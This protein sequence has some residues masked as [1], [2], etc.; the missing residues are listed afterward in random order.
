MK[1]WKDKHFWKKLGIAFIAIIAFPIAILLITDVIPFSLEDNTSFSF[2]F[3]VTTGIMLFF[4]VCYAWYIFVAIARWKNK[5]L[6][7][8]IIDGVTIPVM[9]V[10]VLFIIIGFAISCEL[11]ELVGTG[12]CT[13]VQLRSV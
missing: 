13:K 12:E 4:L 5:N 10:F 11:K 2:E 8:K 7:I 1:L 3:F 9:V 6:R